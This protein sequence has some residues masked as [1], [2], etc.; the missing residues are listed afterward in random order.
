MTPYTPKEFVLELCTKSINGEL[1][2]EN[3]G[4]RVMIDGLKL[5][6]E[7]LKLE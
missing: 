1:R 7:T 3:E 5:Q 2:K 4:L 6:V